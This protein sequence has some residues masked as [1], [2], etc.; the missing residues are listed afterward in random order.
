[1][2]ACT[3]QYFP[4]SSQLHLKVNKTESFGDSNITVCL[5]YPVGAGIESISHNFTI[6]PQ[7]DVLNFTN[8][9]ICFI[10]PYNVPHNVSIISN[11]CGTYTVSA[12][13]EIYYGK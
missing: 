13:L 6:F 10:A 1:M 3:L 12:I 7:V 8:I 5:E 4:A 9:S 2:D 11:T